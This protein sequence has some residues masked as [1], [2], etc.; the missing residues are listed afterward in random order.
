MLDEIATLHAR[1]AEGGHWRE[2]RDE[3]ASLHQS[4]ST[5]DE[6]VILMEAFH[7]L[8]AV[9][10]AVYDSETWSRVE[11]VA[12]GEYRLFLAIEAQEG[13]SMINPMLHDFITKRE[14]EAGRLDPD[15]DLRT[16][17]HAG[18]TV[19]GDSSDL[20]N[21]PPRP[22]NWLAGGLALG[23]VIL[24]LLGVREPVSPLWLIPMGIVVGTFPNQL[25]RNRVIEEAKQRRISRGYPAL[26]K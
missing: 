18:G 26:S 25:A 10:P 6:F 3:I 14:V 9:G 4:A 5:Q 15:S 19:L 1:M 12:S 21:P 17:A 24:W 13:G 2:W 11:P 20:E 23:A 22:G 7:N 16:F 8:M